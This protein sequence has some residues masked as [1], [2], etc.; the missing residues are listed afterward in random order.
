LAPRDGSHAAHLASRTIRL[1]SRDR[2]PAGAA[3]DLAQRHIR[4]LA[5]RFAAIN[6]T[7]R[8]IN[9]T[10]PPYTPKPPSQRLSFC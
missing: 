10:N 4:N 7:S 2:Q 3:R 5:F 8:P 1:T 9:D 6:P